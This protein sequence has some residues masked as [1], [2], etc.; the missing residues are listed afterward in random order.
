MVR[1]T[2]SCKQRRSLSTRAQL[3]SVDMNRAANRVPVCSP[4]QLASW[5]RANNSS[6]QLFANLKRKARCTCDLSS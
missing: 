2:L 1:L 3:C 4:S 5:R 6:R